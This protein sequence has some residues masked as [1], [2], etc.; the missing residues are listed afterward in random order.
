MMRD[1]VGAVEFIDLD[2]L[3]PAIIDVS[4]IPEGGITLWMDQSNTPQGGWGA[5]CDVG[6]DRVAA[7][8]LL[9]GLR[10]AQRIADAGPERGWE[11]VDPIAYS[12]CDQDDETT[13][14]AGR[15]G[16]LSILARRGV[17]RILI[18]PR[19]PVEDFV[20]T[21][22]REAASRLIELVRTAVPV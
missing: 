9:Q 11:P 10:Q 6:F 5:D 2:S 18:A 21:L 17:V 22:P 3:Q 19:R 8:R 1:S 14:S 20:F 13:S 15:L 4:R 12:W 7:K 16:Y